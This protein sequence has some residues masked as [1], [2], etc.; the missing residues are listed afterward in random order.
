M[1]FEDGNLKK[2]GEGDTEKRR[3]RRVCKKQTERDRKEVG[4]VGILAL[5]LPN[6]PILFTLKKHTLWVSSTT[7]GREK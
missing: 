4:A 2:E 1:R 5:L 3:S 7:K 6:H